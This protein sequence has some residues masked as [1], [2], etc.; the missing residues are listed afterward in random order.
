[1]TSPNSGVDM[2]DAAAVMFDGGAIGT[3]SGAA[4]L[5]D[6]DPFQVDIRIF[7]D[8]GVLEIDMERARLEVR[9]HDG[10]HQ[11]CDIE[12]GAG[13]YSCEVPPVRF[14]EVIKGEAN[15]DSPGEVAAR[16]VE[17]IDAMHRSAADGGM[18]VKVY[19]R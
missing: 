8:E 11:Q 6:N 9:R 1:M 16:T 3:V 13:A 4:T 5:P 7:G 19:R 18:P 10:K 2:Y 15:N 17:L 12:P 14:I